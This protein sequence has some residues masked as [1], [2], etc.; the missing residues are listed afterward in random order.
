MKGYA[1]GKDITLDDR[2]GFFLPLRGLERFCDGDVYIGVLLDSYNLSDTSSRKGKFYEDSEINNVKWSEK[3]AITGLNCSL[4]KASQKKLLIK[5]SNIHG[6]PELVW[7][8]M[9]TVFSMEATV[10]NANDQ[11]VRTQGTDANFK[12]KAYLTK[13]G[14]RDATDKYLPVTVTDQ[15]WLSTGIEASGSITFHMTGE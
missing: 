7:N 15:N 9:E 1:T 2:G 5:M 14:V 12:I 10:T 13:N 6:E 8:A 3:V 4:N 11:P